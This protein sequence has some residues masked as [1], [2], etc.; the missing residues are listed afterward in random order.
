MILNATI[1]PWFS[2]DLVNQGSNLRLDLSGQK[3]LDWL[4]LKPV[5]LF[6]KT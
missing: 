1:E 2:H 5:F 4:I 6:S 3:P